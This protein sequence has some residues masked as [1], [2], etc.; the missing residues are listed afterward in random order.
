MLDVQ[1]S[2]NT[3]LDDLQSWQGPNDVLLSLGPPTCN[4]SSTSSFCRCFIRQQITSC[5]APAVLSGG[6]ARSYADPTAPWNTASFAFGDANEL[7]GVNRLSTQFCISGTGNPL[8][9]VTPG[10]ANSPTNLSQALTTIMS[11]G[12]ILGKYIMTTRRGMN[13]YK[14]PYDSAAPKTWTPID[15]VANDFPIS[16]PSIFM[17]ILQNSQGSFSL[18]T[19]PLATLVDGTLPDGTTTY[20]NPLSVTSLGTTQQCSRVSYMV[21]SSEMIPVRRM[22][23]TSE[24]AAPGVTITTIRNGREVAT[25]RIPLSEMVYN[26]P[27]Q[28]LLPN[29]KLIVG[30]PLGDARGNIYDIPDTD[31]SVSPNAEARKGKVGYYMC[32]AATPCTMD[33]WSAYTN[34]AAFDADSGSTVASM[35]ARPVVIDPISGAYRCDDEPALAPSSSCDLRRRYNFFSTNNASTL[36]LQS[37][38]EGSYVINFNIPAGTLSEKFVSTCPTL[39]VQSP[40][41]DGSMLIFSNLRPAPVTLTLE[42]SV[43]DECIPPDLQ[44]ITV[45]A[46][47]TAST[48]IPSAPTPILLTASNAVTNVACPALTEVDVRAPPRATTVFTHNIVDKQYTHSVSQVAADA[49]F[50]ALQDVTA[51]VTNSIDS[52]T[53][54]LLTIV[55]A[56]GIVIPDTDDSNFTA[57]FQDILNQTRNTTQGLIALRNGI[58]ITN[59]TAA[60]DVIA[61][62]AARMNE[63]SQ[64]FDANRQ[65]TQVAMELKA[66]ASA[67]QKINYENYLTALSAANNATKLFEGAQEN[68]TKLAVMTSSAIIKQMITNDERMLTYSGSDP[69]GHLLGGLVSGVGEFGNAVV[70]VAKDAANE[71]KKDIGAVVDGVENL[72]NKALDAAS[73]FPGSL[74]GGLGGLGDLALWIIVLCHIAYTFMQRRGGGGGGGYER[75]KSFRGSASSMDGPTIT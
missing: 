60:D 71:V 64:Q 32:P 54:L 74:F 34:G 9:V 43:C 75:V 1:C 37:V 40:N 39:V 17:L 61:A 58:L 23:M 42:W 18:L 27:A 21:Y 5:R 63:S 12:P 10:L 24:G 49:T 28:S 8:T 50:L 65:L 11:R 38:T 41:S 19:A 25:S 31:V 73:K 30:N 22:L 15:L 48:Y 35:Y 36:M 7:G 66:N 62:G 47:G 67:I 44:T 14:V 68:F 16:L 3:V 55:K 59:F 46:S 72:A 51:R 57:P 53:L 29:D 26:N 20:Y 52:L 6:G 33:E 13:M 69:F 2:A 56:A 45:P 70:G 4:P